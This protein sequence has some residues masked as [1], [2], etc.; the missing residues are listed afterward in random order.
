[1]ITRRRFVKCGVASAITLA[2]YPA[3][4]PARSSTVRA[5][6]VLIQLRGGMDA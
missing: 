6:L 5:R 1:M 3:L 4:S 2:G